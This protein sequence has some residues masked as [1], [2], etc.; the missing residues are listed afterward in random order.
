MLSSHSTNEATISHQ[1]PGV[2]VQVPAALHLIQLPVNVPGKAA[3]ERPS[4]WSPVTHMARVD[5]FLAPSFPSLAQI[6]L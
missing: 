6:W 1:P 3:E 5:K 2:L 4:A